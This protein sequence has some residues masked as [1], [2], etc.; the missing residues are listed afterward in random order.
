MPL[1]GIDYEVHPNP[2]AMT[3]EV[4]FED[5]TRLVIQP[6]FCSEYEGEESDEIDHRGYIDCTLYIPDVFGIPRA[7]PWLINLHLASA[8]IEGLTQIAPYAQI[9]SE[10]RE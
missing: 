1:F 5:G 2:K 6:H 8:L 3:Y 7:F 4:M 9:N 10:L